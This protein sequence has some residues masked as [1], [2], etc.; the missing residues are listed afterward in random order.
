MRKSDIEA[1]NSRLK[2]ELSQLK[3]E[4]KVL[5]ERMEA[6]RQKRVRLQKELKKRRSEHRVE[7]KTGTF[8]FE[9]IKG[10][11][12]SEFV[13]RLS[14][15]LYCR[16]NCGLRSTVEILN[17][18]NE[19]LDG[20]LGDIPSYTTIENWVKKCGLEVYKTA[21]ESLKDTDYT[22]ITDESMMI[23]SE[24]LLLT[25]GVPAEHQGCTKSRPE[26]GSFFCLHLRL[27][28]LVKWSNSIRHESW[29]G[30]D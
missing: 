29:L 5:S 25:F 9:P 21:G 28:N 17:I 11:R 23:G 27:K 19:A 15:L 8:T 18:V 30:T 7:Q 4:N 2:K 24:K 13:V 6:S 16:V 3:K 10:H 22:Q 20:L 12:Y 1:E 14:T 26:A